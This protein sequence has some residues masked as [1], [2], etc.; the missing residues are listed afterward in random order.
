MGRFKSRFA[1]QCFGLLAKT[2]ERL[3]YRVIRNNQPT[4]FE[5]L[6]LRQ[7]QRSPDF[8]F[9][10]IGANDG[11]SS[12]PI[13]KFV[14]E[15]NIAGLA[16]EPL[17]DIFAKLTETYRAFPTVQ[18]A[19]VAVHRTEKSLEI[20]RVDPQKGAELGGWAQGIAS[21][22]ASHHGLTETPS[23]VMVAETVNCVTFDELL[24]SRGIKKFDLLQID[25]EGYDAEI[26]KM[27]DFTRWKPA[28]I[29][30]EHGMIDGLMSAAT[31]KEC[32]NLLIDQ[33]YLVV[34]ELYDAVAYQPSVLE[35]SA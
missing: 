28:I 17:R 31:F 26:I 30:F 24:D 13:H 34:T 5:P 4:F 16:V 27:I 22:N 7:L 19:N 35:G 2:L 29:R 1:S 33:G 11:V 15:N 20:H 21:F 23:D 9:V 6:L 32:V 12:D 18:L 25:T 8:F 14:T 3:G 10:Q